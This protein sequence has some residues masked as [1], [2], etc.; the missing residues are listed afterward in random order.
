MYTLVAPRC[1]SCARITGRCFAFCA[2]STSSEVIS[3]ELVLAQEEAWGGTTL[4]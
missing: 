1:L 3:F 2:A 4:D